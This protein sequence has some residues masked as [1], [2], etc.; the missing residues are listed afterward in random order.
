LAADRHCFACGSA[1]LVPHLSVAGEAGEPGMIPT[2][3]RYGTALADI[4]RCTACGHMQLERMP[5]EAELAKS[6][7]EAESEDYLVEEA[8]QRATAAAILER[9]ERHRSPGALLDVGSWVGFFSAEARDRGWRPTGVEP[10]EFAAAQ[11]RERLGLDVLCDELLEAPLAGRSFDAAFMG[12][13]IEHLPDPGAALERVREL[14]AP[15]GVLA[16]AL[17]DA[18]SRV[19]RALGTRWWSVIPTHVHYFTRGSLSTLLARNGYA[20][21]EDSTAPKAFSV[22]YYMQRTS[23]YSGALAGALLGAARAAGASERIW[24]PDF[25]DRMLVLARPR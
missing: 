23:G 25:R 20:V 6:Y 17:P 8:G 15:G 21:L 3:D 14:L 5:A 13:V 12:D 16:L 4:E 11:A 7:A 1:S 10:S 19:A 9:I 24:A 22:G 2:S 18:G